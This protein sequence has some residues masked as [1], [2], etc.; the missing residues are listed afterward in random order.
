MTQL[1]RA[2][3]SRRDPVAGVSLNAGS[4]IRRR[5]AASVIASAKRVIWITAAAGSG[6]TTLATQICEHHGQGFAWLRVEPPMANMG[7][8][9]TAMLAAFRKACPDGELPALASESIAGPVDYLRRLIAAASNSGATMLVLDDT[10]TLPAGA[11]P[12]HVLAEAMRDAPGAMRIVLVSREPAHPAWLWYTAN[13]EV[14]TIDF[15]ELRLGFDEASALIAQRPESDRGWTAKTLLSASGGWI[16]GARLLLQAPPGT[17]RESQAG[18]IEHDMSG[19][20]DLIVQELVVPLTDDDRRLLIH[21]AQMPNL[22]A[23]ILAEA[24]EMPHG[25]RALNRL[26]QNMLFVERDGRGQIQVHDLLKAALARRYADEQSREEQQRLQARAGRALLERGEIGDGLS[27]LASSEAWEPLCEA[28]LAH[29]KAMNDAGELGV[30]LAA[31]EQVPQEQLGMHVGLRYWLGVCLLSINPVRARELLHDTFLSVKDDI[32]SD[33]LIPAWTALVD[34]IWLEWVD[35]TRFDE[36]IAMLPVLEESAAAKGPVAESMLARGAFAALSFRCPAKEDFPSWEE[37]NLGFFWRP[38]PRHETIRRGIQLLFRYCWGDGERWKAS[39]V[40][41]RLNYVFDEESAPVADI[42]TRYV[43]STEFMSLFEPD[44]EE[45]FLTLEQ[46]LSATARHQQGFWDVTLINAALYRAMSLEDR[47]RAQGY[48]ALLGERLGPHSNP[49]H[50]AIHEH[51]LGYDHWLDG[52]HEGALTHALAAFRAS[53]ATGFSIS[54]LYYGI[55]VAAI[56][57]SMGRRREALAWMRQARRRAVEQRSFILIFLTCLRGAALALSSCRPH[58]ADIYLRAAMA[59]GASKRFYIHQWIRRDEMA[60]LMQR[61]L[62][63]GI[64]ADYASELIQ[65]FDLPGNDAESKCNIALVT[66]GRFDIV[67]DGKSRLISAK[68]QRGPMS[69]AVHLVAAGRNGEDAETLMDRLWPE[70]DGQSARRRLKS[71]VYRLRQLFGNSAAVITAAGRVTLN[72]AVVAVDS[73][74]L[75]A[76]SDS[77]G[78]VPAASRPDV[79]ELYG[80]AFVHQFGDHVSLLVYRQHLERRFTALA[81]EQA[82]HFCEHGDWVRALHSAR[83]A[84]VRA[85]HDERLL[86]LTSR[87][88]DALGSDNERQSLKALMHDEHR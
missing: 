75:E 62:A 77:A 88:V 85:G 21:V 3:T 13:D 10:H 61:S 43:V 57:Q 81:S 46:G 76:I 2:T 58:R 83:T 32:D 48:L 66:L 24:L 53:V 39:Q 35:C 38:M 65:I 56:L 72:P 1:E 6:K 5:H 9:L 64:E 18:L 60:R 8:F 37:R 49:H 44:S 63:A 84:L 11:A 25:G 82:E 34:A 17:A 86:M 78:S 26:V 16:L 36:L 7:V 70:A 4:P 22:P 69:L 79:I 51:F 33:L 31:L 14:A 71:T 73:W 54:P 67:V 29:A 47:K 15:E 50:I 59:A 55:A 30:L 40:R 87:A 27:L 23:P 19:L 20:L 52:R 12:L 41:N 42:C 45:V 74:R 28:V 80:G 68:P